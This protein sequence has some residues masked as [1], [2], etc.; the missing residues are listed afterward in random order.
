MKSRWLA[1]AL[2]LFALMVFGYACK[3]GGGDAFIVVL[4]T[5]PADKQ[6][7]VQVEARIGFRINATID[8]AT[9]T[10]DTFFVTDSQGTRVPGTLAIDDEEPDVA[11]L[12]PDELSVITNFTATITTGLASSSG[13]TLEEDFEWDFTTIDSAWGED[14][15][16]EAVGTGSSNQPQ[17]AVDG[18]S[19]ALAVWEYTEP[20]GTRIWANHYTRVDLWEVPEPIDDGNQTSTNPQLATDDAGNGFAVWEQGGAAIWTN[21]YAVDEGWGTPALLQTVEIT[22]ARSPSIAADREGNAIAVWVQQEMDGPN[23]VVWASRYEPGSGWGA[24]ASIDPM[25]TTAAGPKTSVGMD[26]EGNA[27]AVWARQTVTSTGRGWVLWARRYVAGEGWGTADTATLIKPDPET[28]A[29]DERLSVGPNGDAFVVWEQNDPMRQDPLGNDIDDIWGVRFSGS[30][31]EAPER[32]DDYDAGNKRDPDIAVDGMGVA[33][34]VWSQ[35]DLDFNNIWANAYI[36]GPGWGA[37]ELIEPPNEDPNEDSSAAS[38]RVGVNAAG[39]AFVLWRQNWQD[40]ASIWSNRRDPEEMSWTPMRAE[41]IE[42]EAR[43]AGVPMVAVDENRHA[44]A[45]WPHGLGSGADWVRTN[46]FE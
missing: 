25:P 1:C 3:G 11:V 18:Q 40:W 19:N 12:T 2:A 46:R 5:E 42:D 24:A 22:N 10:N 32:I 7:D 35:A 36:P 13:A 44:H 15:W 17:I 30:A 23:R 21:R 28:S 27:I 4:D 39:N 6:T 29:L 45:A 33:H 20:A 34:A 14:E 9:L 16:L 41:R 43:A 31:W 37:P 38:P 8:P 26:D